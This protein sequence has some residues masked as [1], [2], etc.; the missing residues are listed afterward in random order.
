MWR[1]IFVGL[2]A[3]AGLVALVLGVVALVR[4]GRLITAYLIALAAMTVMLTAAIVAEW[5]ELETVSRIV[6]VAFAGLAGVMVGRGWAARRIVGRGPSAAYVEHLG[7]TLVAL[8]DGFLVIAVLDL[9]GS[10]V[11]AVLTGVAV[12]VAGH[13]VLG[14]VRRSVLRVVPSP[15]G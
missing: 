6:F 14:A 2:H 13:F 4:H 9:S 8:V 15:A 3:V 1:S 11:A 7:F 12:A 5:N 10:T